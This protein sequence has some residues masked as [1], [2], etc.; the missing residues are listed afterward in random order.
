MF[1]RGRGTEEEEQQARNG[2]ARQPRS[3]PPLGCVLAKCKWVEYDST[4][5]RSE[6]IRETG[7]GDGRTELR[8]LEQ[9]KGRFNRSSVG[10]GTNLE[11]TK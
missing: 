3:Y 7:A 10:V 8:S 1:P 9:F 11:P 5:R 2:S 6:E 4:R